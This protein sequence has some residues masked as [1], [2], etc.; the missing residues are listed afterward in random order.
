MMALNQSRTMPARPPGSP[1]ASP[2][3]S[4]EEP[5]GGAEESSAAVSSVGSEEGSAEAG[6][7]D[8]EP[9]GEA[10]ES[11]WPGSESGMP[12]WVS[13]LPGVSWANAA[14]AAGPINSTN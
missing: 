7:V 13:Q 10:V 3:M 14:P 11:F 9:S 2:Y 4:S 12:F 6:S 5:S 1:S 8:E